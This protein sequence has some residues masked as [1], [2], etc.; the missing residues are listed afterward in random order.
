MKSSV[1]CMKEVAWEVMP[2][3]TEWG[4]EGTEDEDSAKPASR[5][6]WCSCPRFLQHPHLKGFLL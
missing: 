2:W 3:V 4:L 6:A 5:A 1:V